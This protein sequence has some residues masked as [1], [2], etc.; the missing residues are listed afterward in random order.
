VVQSLAS[1]RT[2][3][4]TAGTLIWYRIWSPVARL[5]VTIRARRRLHDGRCDEETFDGQ[6]RDLGT[7]GVWTCAFEVQSVAQMSLA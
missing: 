4:G 5:D 3:R 7:V 2:L 6:G 1:G